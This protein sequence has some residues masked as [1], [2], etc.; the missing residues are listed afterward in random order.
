[1]GCSKAVPRASVQTVQ[2][3][4]SESESNAWMDRLGAFREAFGHCRVPPNWTKIP[5]LA[6]WVSLQRSGFDSLPFERLEQLYRFGFDFGADRAWLSR[7]LELLE[8]KRVHGHSNVPARWPANPQ[9]GG[10]L[11]S[12]RSRRATMPVARRKLFDRLGL[13]WSPLASTWNR[14]Y[15]DLL[16]FKTEHGHCNVPSEW[17][18]NPTLALW[19]GNQRHR[20]H[21]LTPLQKRLLNRLAFDWS[22]AETLW[23]THLKELNGFRELHGHCNVPP[24]W[25]GNPALG[26]WVA[27][28]R[29]R[30]EDAVSARWRRSLIALEFEWSPSRAQWWETRFSELQAFKDQFGHCRVPK[31]WA[32]NPSLGSWVSTQRMQRES[33]S[34]ERRQRLAGLGFV[35]QAKLMSPARSWEERFQELIQFKRRFGHCDVPAVWAENQPLAEWVRRQRGRDQAKLGADQRRRLTE[36]GYCWAPREINWEERFA[37]LRA[38]EKIHGHCNVPQEAP[39]LRR[40]VLRQRYRKRTLSE[41]RVRKLDQLNFEWLRLER[42]GESV[43]SGAAR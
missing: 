42:G 27:E 36:L 43:P 1:M 14:R 40:W 18:Q 15:G 13:D 29:Q 12:Q 32:P 3:Q 28:L 33:L 38:F 24:K 31:D 7:F 22:P 4:S 26:S 9:L 35:W 2:P 6:K 23:K 16:A 37:E 25:S 19:V 39:E 20:K 8:F 5:A 34:T 41:E 30:G 21:L 17:S 10:W 11:S